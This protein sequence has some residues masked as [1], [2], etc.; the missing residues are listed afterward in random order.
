MKEAPA[1]TA[2]HPRWYRSRVPTYWWLW[3]WPYL[4]FVLREL[5]S[6]SVAYFVVLTLVQLGSLCEGP[7]AYAEFQ[8]WLKSPLALV[9]SAISFFFVL[10]HTI[11]WFNLAPRAM[12]LRLG[13]KRVPDVVIAVSNYVVWV[14]VSAVVAWLLLGG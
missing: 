13:G 14:I 7:E 10:L 9:L 12:A 3:K 11:T 5:S 2:F 6:V 8:N 1:Y 4:K